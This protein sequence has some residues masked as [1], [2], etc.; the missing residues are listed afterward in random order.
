MGGETFGYLLLGIGTYAVAKNQM[1]NFVN[2]RFNFA[3]TFT[4]KAN[5]R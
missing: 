1:D 4:S 3:K 2:N 5:R